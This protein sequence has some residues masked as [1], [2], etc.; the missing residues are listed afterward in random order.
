MPA[1]TAGQGDVRATPVLRSADIRKEL[2]RIFSKRRRSYL[3]ALYGRGEPGE[4]IARG[5][6]FRVIP[7]R[8][9]L[10]LR[11]KMPTPRLGEP[12]C[13]VF[14][15]DWTDQTLPLDLAC[16]LACGRMLQ[17]GRDTRLTSLFGA[18]AAQPELLNTSLATLLLSGAVNN[19]KKVTGQQL[20]TKDA[21]RRFL[22]AMFDLPLEGELSAGL[23]IS[24][25]VDNEHGPAL[26]ARANED[27]VWARVRKEVA[28]FVRSEAGALAEVAWR[29]WECNQ[30]RS[31]AELCLVVEAVNPQL[32]EG[33]YE[34]GLLRGEL[35]SRAPTWGESLLAARDLCTPALLDDVLRRLD[36]S[37]PERTPG[38]D[39]VARADR[40]IEDSRF[41]EALGRSNR[42]PVGYAAR[43]LGLGTALKALVQQPTARSL[44]TVL[45]RYQE[46]CGHTSAG[47]EPDGAKEQLCMGVRLAAYLVHRLSEKQQK[48]AGAQYQQALDLAERYATEGGF[49]DWARQ[50]LRGGGEGVLGEA[51]KA[52]LGRVDE[53]CHEDD[54]RFAQGLVSWVE[55]GQPATQVLPLVKGSEKLVSAFLDPGR[56]D[57]KLLVVLMDGMSWANAVELVKSLA[58]EPDRWSPVVWRPG[59]ISGRTACSL[60]PVLASLPTS[61]DVSRSAFFA[62]K[63]MAP[64]SPTSTS[65]DPQRWANNR[66]VRKAIGE[67]KDDPELKIGAKLMTPEGLLP[68]VVD[69]FKRKEPPR[70]FAVVVNAID[71]QL[72]AGRQMWAHCTPE[73]IKPL[74]ELLALAANAGM[75][76]LLVSDHGHVPG[77]LLKHRG[78]KVRPGG[79]RWRPLPEGQTPE[80]FEVLLPSSGAW[81]PRGTEAVAA[82]WDRTACYGNPRFGEHGGACLAEVVA[83]AVLVAP[84]HLAE[85]TQGELTTAPL[86]EPDWWRLVVPGAR[87][88]PTTADK[89]RKKDGKKKDKAQLALPDIVSPQPPPPSQ[90]PPSRTPPAPALV[91]NL[92]RSKVFRARVKGL[93]ED[94]VK[95]AL[96][97]LAVLVAAGGKMPEAEFARRCRVLPYRVAGLVAQLAEVLNHDGYTVVQHDRSGHQVSLNRSRL[98]QLYEVKA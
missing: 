30:G 91:D 58:D 83:P 74:R 57:R 70:L 78:G 65:Q 25:C 8:C 63:P 52:V 64:C 6:S 92:S 15:V 98:M 38:R 89:P 73:F 4:V 9:E 29:A 49:V 72:K 16:R 34:Q 67:G 13:M 47:E 48:T 36:R 43:K 75:A 61:T 88:V 40:A 56:L 82:I 32:G 85:V 77:D 19:L 31:F 80:P 50:R 53:L 5:R 45:E 41:K 68:E 20:L 3:A 10:E 69:V 2:E 62:G 79:A 17:I 59:G 60:P 87:P 14:L 94:R 97:V 95:D 24:W 23:V 86:L 7:T 44:E 46:L 55:A 27:E 21:Y 33:S 37:S 26:V 51:L 84:E 22:N 71:D 11:A 28:Q 12:P 66:H 1:D 42:L 54:R 96:E 93:S 18:Q 76:V 35:R 90:Q 81:R 39:L